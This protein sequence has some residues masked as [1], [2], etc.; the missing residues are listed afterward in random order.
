MAVVSGVTLIACGGTQPEAKQANAN[1]DEERSDYDSTANIDMSA[2][3]G[4]LP[5]DEAIYA[6]KQSFRDIQD[7]FMR[8]ARRIDFIGGQISIQ[9]WVDSNGQVA[10]VFAET[11][12][13]GDRQTER[14]MFDVLRGAQ[15]P[16]P[17]GGPIAV[18][19]NAFEF[20]MTGDVRAPVSWDEDRVSGVLGEM[21][22]RIRECKDHSSE[23]FMATVYVDT[24][25]TALSVGIAAPDRHQEANSDCL[26]DL[27]SSASYPS[28]GSWPAKVSFRL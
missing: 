4:A 19:Q 17:V 8:G 22:S 15:W 5:E 2:E 23:K 9:V 21:R 18:A 10:T 7:C 26:I 11:S 27:L 1:L 25:G 6:F 3:V 28:P 14:C 24:D 20:E 12:T 13:L 16:R